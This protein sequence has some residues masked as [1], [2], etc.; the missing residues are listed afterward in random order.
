MLLIVESESP[1]L[2][3]RFMYQTQIEVRVPSYVD[4]ARHTFFDKDEERISRIGNLEAIIKLMPLFRFEDVVLS[5]FH[6][7]ELCYGTYI[8]FYNVDHIWNYDKVLANSSDARLIYVPSYMSFEPP[9][10]DD[11]E[12]SPDAM[13]YAFNKSVMKKTRVDL[14][15]DNIETVM[16]WVYA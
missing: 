6:L 15:K 13:E 4:F 1:L 12:V 10:E 5:G 8:R 2:A 3:M 16:K 11:I 9:I 14:S 7:T